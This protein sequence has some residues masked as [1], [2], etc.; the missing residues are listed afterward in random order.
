[1]SLRPF[2]KAA[3][4]LGDKFLYRSN[5]NVYMKKELN[6]NNKNE[7]LLERG[8]EVKNQVVPQKLS[9][10]ENSKK[11]GVIQIN[12]HTTATAEYLD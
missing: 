3:V 11:I 7:V 1:M 8:I 2:E 10:E 4:R 6:K 5:P 9:L 12:K